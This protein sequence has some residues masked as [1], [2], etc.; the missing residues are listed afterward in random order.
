MKR[1]YS[2][3]IKMRPTSTDQV[4]EEN[5]VVFKEQQAQSRFKIIKKPSL[6]YQ[7]IP[8]PSVSFQRARRIESL[9]E[10]FDLE[11]YIKYKK[12]IQYKI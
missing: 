10:E 6:N 1:K 2:K 11:R 7:A 4:Q 3:Q 9:V 12:V 5:P 8:G